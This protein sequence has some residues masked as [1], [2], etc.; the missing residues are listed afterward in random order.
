M[1]EP[2]WPTIILPVWSAISGKASPCSR[3]PGDIAVRTSVASISMRA[4]RRAFSMMWRVT[5]WMATRSNGLSLVWTM[6]A[7]MVR[8]SSGQIDQDIADVVDGA[9]A[10]AFDQGR[11]IH[12]ADDGRAGDHVSG[13]QLGAIIDH[14]GLL[15]PVHP[16]GVVT[17]SG[18]DGVAVTL[19]EF[20][21]WQVGGAAP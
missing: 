11:G 21:G 15:S 12:F 19:L 16:Q 7:G 9:D 20:G 4:L 5:G 13:A 17:H 10:A 8:A 1:K 2:N 6:V 14:G 18:G 3:M